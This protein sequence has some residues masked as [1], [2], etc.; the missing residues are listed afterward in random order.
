MADF[1]KGWYSVPLY[2]TSTILQ[3]L[4]RKVN[5]TLDGSFLTSKVH[6]GSRNI[7]CKG[8][9]TQEGEKRTDDST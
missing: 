4:P 7:A 9:T 8:K 6:V 5:H 2:T 1:H 3:L